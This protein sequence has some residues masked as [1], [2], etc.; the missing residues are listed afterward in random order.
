MNSEENSLKKGQIRDPE[1]IHPGSG[2]NPFRIRILD[3]GGKKPP[4]PH[5]KH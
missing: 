2:K 5:P 1:E 4:D 3:P